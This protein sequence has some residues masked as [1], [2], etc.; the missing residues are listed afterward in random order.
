MNRALGAAIGAMAV[1][2]SV[3][4][5]LA[6]SFDCRR[7]KAAD[8]KAI[9]ADRALNDRDVK[10]TVMFDIAKHLVAMGRRGQ[11]QDEQSEWLKGRRACGANRQCLNATYAHRIARLQ[12]VIDDV[13]SRGPY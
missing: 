6:A 8:E 13:A 4:P 1:I 9:C 10:M 3:H 5:A 12:G 11:L 7:A 2:L